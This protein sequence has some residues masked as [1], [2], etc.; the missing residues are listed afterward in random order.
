MEGVS[1]MNLDIMLEALFS[2]AT[3]RL[4]DRFLSNEK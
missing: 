3:L 4:R 1:K 2:L